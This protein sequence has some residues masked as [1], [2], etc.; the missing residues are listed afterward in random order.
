MRALVDGW[1]GLRRV[2]WARIFCSVSFCGLA[3]GYFRSLHWAGSGLLLW[4]LPFIELNFSE[5]CGVREADNYGWLARD[6]RRRECYMWGL[7]SWAHISLAQFLFLNALGPKTCGRR[8]Q[9]QGTM[10]CHLSEEHPSSFQGTMVIRLERTCVNHIIWQ[11]HL[12]MEGIDPPRL[13]GMADFFDQQLLLLI[14]INHFVKRPFKASNSI[15]AL[16]YEPIVVGETSS[17]SPCS[18]CLSAGGLFSRTINDFVFGTWFYPK[19]RWL[20]S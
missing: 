19:L 6:S 18:T 5:G 14:G 11:P 13:H 10:P 9:C 12:L 7:P 3:G 17:T 8:H 15:T 4:G 2:G 1:H 16:G 20:H